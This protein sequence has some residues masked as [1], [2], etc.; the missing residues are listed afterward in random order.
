MLSGLLSLRNYLIISAVVA[1]IIYLLQLVAGTFLSNGMRSLNLAARGAGMAAALADA[2]TEPI[3][4]VFTPNSPLGA[5]AGGVLWPM[6]ALW[7]MLALAV[8]FFA[9]LGRGFNQA[10]NTIR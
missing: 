4:I 7:I 8:F 10:A 6:L 3:R 2:I 1:G 5:I 9:I